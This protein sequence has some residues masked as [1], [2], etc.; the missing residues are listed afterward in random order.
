MRRKL[1][2][3]GDELDALAEKLTGER[4][5][6]VSS[7]DIL[8]ALILRHEALRDIQ[9]SSDVWNLDASVESIEGLVRTFDFQEL[10]I[11]IVHE[12]TLPWQARFHT[13]ANIKVKGEVWTIH[14]YDAD[15]F[16]SNPHAHNFDQNLKLDLRNGDCY[17]GRVL[18]CTLPRKELIEI[19][20]RCEQRGVVLQAIAV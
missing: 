9:M 14:K 13:K 3:L 17:R 18:Q 8:C 5:Y 19:R 6:D 7:K 10:R 2:L 12:T 11:E 1:E 16:P 4:G 15:P 20:S